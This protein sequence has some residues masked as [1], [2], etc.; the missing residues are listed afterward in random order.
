VP[1]VS[2]LR[3]RDA[4]DEFVAAFQQEQQEKKVNVADSPDAGDAGMMD[5]CDAATAAMTDVGAPVAT[6]EMAASD[7]GGAVNSGAAE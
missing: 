1:P 7:N 4:Y 5:A 6:E 3:P 2:S